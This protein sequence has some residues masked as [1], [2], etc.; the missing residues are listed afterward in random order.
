MA[1][2]LPDE[3]INFCLTKKIPLS[4][5]WYWNWQAN[6]AR[7]HLKADLVCA[8]PAWI[9]SVFNI[10]YVIFDYFTDVLKSQFRLSHFG[11][12]PESVH[13]P[14]LCN[15]WNNHLSWNGAN[16]WVDGCQLTPQMYS[17]LSGFR[18][19][20]ISADSSVVVELELWV[21]SNLC[22]A[23]SVQ[24]R[25]PTVTLTSACLFC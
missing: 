23:P 19:R 2:D 6:L 4:H 14:L 10:W 24:V 22:S 17:G 11:I 3:H 7:L 9:I 15:T 16:R 12:L 1:L 20:L 21:V 25:W 8:A 5:I 13:R 18:L